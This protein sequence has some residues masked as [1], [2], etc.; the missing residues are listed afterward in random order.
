MIAVLGALVLVG[1]GPRDAVPAAEAPVA[2]AEPP[3]AWDA[4]PDP[5]RP[6]AAARACEAGDPA[7]CWWSGVDR[8]WRASDPDAAIAAWTRGCATGDARCC[9]AIPTARAPVAAADADA[10]NVA[11]WARCDA[12]DAWGC[13]GLADR[14][15]RG[16][17]ANPSDKDLGWIRNQVC[18]LQLDYGCAPH[19]DWAP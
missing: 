13:L 19:A 14:L 5:E 18:D 8:R 6:D 12:D 1:C 11:L 7:A 10:A 2:V 17:G 9:A 3:P 4:V 16:E 15:L